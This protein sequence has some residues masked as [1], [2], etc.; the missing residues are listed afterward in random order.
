MPQSLQ[1]DRDGTA[2]EADLVQANLSILLVVAVTVV[3]AVLYR[4]HKQVASIP[5]DDVV[6]HMFTDDDINIA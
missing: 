3:A 2:R 4:R 5:D 1:S 6:F